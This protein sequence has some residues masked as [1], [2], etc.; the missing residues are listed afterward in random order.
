MSKMTPERIAGFK[1]S[2]REN[3]ALCLICGSSVTVHQKFTPDSAYSTERF[4]VWVEGPCLGS[5]QE[6]HDREVEILAHAQGQ[7]FE[8]TMLTGMNDF[9]ENE[10][11]RLRAAL[12]QIAA[13][14]CT[15][16]IPSTVH[17]MTREIERIT[18]AALGGD[19]VPS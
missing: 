4:D 3:E 6:H 16:T 18:Q 12:T 13:L 8:R 14:S 2:L 5:D 10:N 19:E 9:L 17:R 11:H 1:D 7:L 15:S